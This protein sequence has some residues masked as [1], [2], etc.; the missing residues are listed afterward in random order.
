MFDIIIHHSHADAYLTRA[1][2]LVIEGAGII[3]ADF[4]SGGPHVRGQQPH[5][6]AILCL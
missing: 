5:N 2:F 4:L 1:C 3:T 6:S